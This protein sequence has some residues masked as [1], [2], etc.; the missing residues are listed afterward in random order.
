MIDP[1]DVFRARADARALLWRAGEYTLH[2]AVDELQ[3]AAERTGLVRT[4]GQD[5][6]QAIL[7]TAFADPPAAP[8]LEEA[9]PRNGCAQSTLD[10]AAWLWFQVGDEQRFS[11]FLKDHSNSEQAAILKHIKQ[12]EARNAENGR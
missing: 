2:E 11:R 8:D 6:V 1:V 9:P 5:G 4:I 7:A 12:I 3:A 10:A